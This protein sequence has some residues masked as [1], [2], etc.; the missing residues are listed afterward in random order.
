M[1]NGAFCPICGAKRPGVD[2]HYETIHSL[3]S[4]NE[5]RNQSHNFDKY[6]CHLLVSIPLEPSFG[7]TCSGSI[8]PKV[9]CWRM[10]LHTPSKAI[11]N[12]QM[13]LEMGVSFLVFS[14]LFSLCT[15]IILLICWFLH[16]GSY[17][18]GR[19]GVLPQDAS[20][21]LIYHCSPNM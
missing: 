15:K 2:L 9:C 19:G 20:R 18:G 6:T 14:L 7:K 21:G 13:K 12:F 11:F 10:A 3:C 4:N 5:F 16:L 1:P 17:P 8:F